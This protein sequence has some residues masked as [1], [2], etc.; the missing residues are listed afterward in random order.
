MN[1]YEILGVAVTASD[2]E[3]K[4]SYRKLAMKYHPDRNPGDIIAENKC[5]EINEAYG[6]LSEPSKRAE[7]DQQLKY[8]SQTYNSPHEE[9]ID[10]DDF[11]RNMFSKGSPFEDIFGA[12]ANTVPP[13][14]HVTLSFWEAIFGVTKR[15]EFMVMHNNKPQ[16]RFA[17][18]A[19]PPGM[20]DNEGLIVDVDGKDIILQIKVGQDDKFVRDHLDLY[21]NVDLPFSIAALGGKFIFPHWEGDVEVTVP[22]GLQPG[23]RLLLANKGIAKDMFRGDLYIKCNI[24]VPKTLTKRQKELLEEFRET[25]QNKPTVLE[26]LRQLWNNLFKK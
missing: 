15:F 13:T 2:D 11:V 6:T 5:K 25:E 1:Y 14:Y 10:I 21:T 9:D 22:P 23:Q 17:Q 3:I 8:Q 26:N 20:N 7:Y 12:R 19:F 16:K 24:S 4:K 18:V